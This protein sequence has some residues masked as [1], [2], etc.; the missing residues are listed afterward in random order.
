MYILAIDQ[1]T[2]GTTTVLYDLEGRPAA[3]AYREFTQHYPGP[4]L[5][6]HDPE[7][8]WQ[9]VLAT[10]AEVCGSR[11]G[12]I[13]AVGITNQRETTVL[14]SRSTGKPL[15]NAIVWQC[16]RTTDICNRLRPQE[17]MIRGKTGLPVDP[18]FSGTKV[19][20]LL[21]HVQCPGPEDIA[22]G[23]IDTWLIWKLTGGRV[24][25]T[26]YTNASRTLLFDIETR[27]WDPE[28]CRLLGIPPEIL[29]EVRRS[30]D[31]YGS[32]S[33]VK[34]IRGVPV[35]GV[36]G[37]QQAALFGQGCFDRGEAKNTYGTGC[38]LLM[39]TGDRRIRSDKGL[40]STLAVGGDGGPCH[41]V[42]GAVFIAGAAI[43]WL[44]DELQVLERA[45]DSEAAAVSLNGN[46]GVYFVPAFVGLGA[47]H[48]NPDARGTVTGLTRGTGRAH[49]IRAALEAMA[50]Q[51][52]DVLV[53]MEEE[54]GIRIPELA[55]DGGA[56]ANNFLAQ[57][58]A[59]ILGRPVV[60]P[61][62]IESTSLG[63]ACLAGLKAGVW[64]SAAELQAF[65]HTERT[66]QPRIGDEARE[67]L[68]AGWR[69]AL[70]KTMQE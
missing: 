17:D 32:V 28:L 5:V 63:A 66:F 68:L 34:E 1:G 6:E 11:Q 26:D 35:L 62:V 31:E 60:R 40:L 64:K 36:A 47:P 70:R 25:A 49:I 33:E 39:N 14:W 23:T 9:T 21:D 18:Y 19:R 54:T 8:I 22:F 38:F 45:A 41:A 16:R 3:K 48:W 55:V 10:V 61:E 52:L 24:H 50:Y 7:E 43:Q 37:D 69:A 51:S 27:Q 67:A 2:T 46:D 53:A 29:P 20:W 58:Q 30:V 59:D 56:I 44:R 12:E 57:F 13:G 4:G 15:H 65:R 42:E